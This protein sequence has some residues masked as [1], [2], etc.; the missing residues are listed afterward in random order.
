M[1]KRV[2]VL[3]VAL[4]L[5]ATISFAQDKVVTNKSEEA[6]RLFA[7][8]D[9]ELFQMLKKNPDLLGSDVQV[10]NRGDVATISVPDTLSEK[11]NEQVFKAPVTVA[12][13]RLLA[14]H[15]E[16]AY[17]IGIGGLLYWGFKIE[18]DPGAVAKKINALLPEAGKLVS[19]GPVWA[20]SEKRSIGD[21]M[22]LWHAGGESGAAAKKGTVERVL[23]I[24]EDTLGTSTLYCSLQGSVTAPLLHKL[25]PDLLPKEYP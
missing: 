6:L 1:S 7:Q 2:S 24:E 20:R 13:L 4:I 23:V 8:C 10:E 14:W 3:F 12:G 21:P 25:R 11:G 16:I 17:D 22:D 19:A 18:G 15:N 9:A 5:N